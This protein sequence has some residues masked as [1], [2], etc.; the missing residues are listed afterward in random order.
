MGCSK[1]QSPKGLSRHLDVGVQDLEHLRFGHR[2]GGSGMLWTQ[3]PGSLWLGLGS[4]GAQQRLWEPPSPL[5][6][7]PQLVGLW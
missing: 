6:E 5:Y 4:G 7:V 3:T 1:I 2:L